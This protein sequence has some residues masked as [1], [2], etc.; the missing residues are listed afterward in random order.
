M[1]DE[2]GSESR[3][4]LAEIW[5]EWLTQ[6][7]RQMNA[8]LNESMSTDAAS[9]GVGSFVEVYA[10]FQRN[11]TQAME[12]YLAVMNIP[13]RTDIVAVGERLTAIETR[14]SRI[15]E[16]LLIAAD[17]VD[18]FDLNPRAEPARTRSPWEV[19]QPSSESHAPLGVESSPVPEELRR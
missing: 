2:G 9:R 7:E 16:T 5:R 15:E 17:A 12:R 14:L 8:F 3:R 18:H 19:T 13:A 4:D 6:S 1:T 10:V 11:F